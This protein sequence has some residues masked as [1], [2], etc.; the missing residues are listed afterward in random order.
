[1]MQFDENGF[2]TPFKIIETDFEEFKET[3]VTNTRREYLFEE[4]FRFLQTL[5][6]LGLGSFFQWINGSFVTQKNAPKD[7]DV[8]TFIDYRNLSSKTEK[9][10]PKIFR[11]ETLDC[12]F[13]VSY[14]EEHKSYNLYKMDRAEWYFL[15]STTRRD[16]KTGKTWN[17]GFVQLNF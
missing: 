16:M 10:L 14:P 6:G 5:Q 15:F 3:F 9:A 13:V 4:Y 7:M 2:L 1:M 17:K 11:T 8:V 12:Y